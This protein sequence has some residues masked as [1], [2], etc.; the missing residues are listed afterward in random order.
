MIT[1]DRHDSHMINK[2]CAAHPRLYSEPG[3]SGWILVP[4]S[5]GCLTN[6][7]GLKYL[8]SGG[9]LLLH[10]TTRINFIFRF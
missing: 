6:H 4:V 9:I 1:F 10:A 8:H 7:A 5:R 2:N 3:D